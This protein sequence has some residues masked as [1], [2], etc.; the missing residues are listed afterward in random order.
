[1]KNQKGFTVIVV[2]FCVFIV[3]TLTGWTVNLVKLVKCDFESPYKAEV[4][5][6][7]GLFPPI[8]MIVAWI[9]LGK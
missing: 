5:R 3:F 1:M 7:I 6:T 2:I 4:I 8:G 9:D